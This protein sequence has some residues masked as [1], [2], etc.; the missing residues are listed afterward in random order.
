MSEEEVKT[1]EQ[2]K[3]PPTPQTP[4]D[5]QKVG[6]MKHR[7]Y[8]QLV[9][10]HLHELIK[11]MISSHG[12]SYQTKVNAAGALVEAVQFALDFGLNIVKCPIRQ[13]GT[14]FAQEVNNLA[15]IL[16]QAQDNRMLLLALQMKKQ[17]ETVKEGEKNEE[18]IADQ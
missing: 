8:V 15:G 13:E 6:E 10:T 18:T 1:E 3:T 12:V 7:V 11:T 2:P 9:G 4:E 17:E 16:A 14:K 5:L